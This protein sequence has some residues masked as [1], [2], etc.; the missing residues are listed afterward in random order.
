[1]NRKKIM[2]PAECLKWMVTND[3]DSIL[4]G[5]DK[6]ILYENLV[7]IPLTANSKI[8]YPIDANLTLLQTD[9]YA[10]NNW[11]LLSIYDKIIVCAH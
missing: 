7:S 9:L 1:M 6:I 5:N 8:F 11:N 3:T 10:N 2:T 4:N